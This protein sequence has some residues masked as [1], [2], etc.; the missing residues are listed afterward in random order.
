MRWGGST[1]MIVSIED[2]RFQ[3]DHP[4]RCDW[5]DMEVSCWEDAGRWSERKYGPNYMRPNRKMEPREKKG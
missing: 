5:Y 4:C 2:E 3:L 1:D